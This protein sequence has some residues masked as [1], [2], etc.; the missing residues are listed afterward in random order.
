MTTKAYS[1]YERIEKR[2]HRRDN[3]RFYSIIV[4]VL[5]AI[6]L[7]GHLK[8]KSQNLPICSTSI[9]QQY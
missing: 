1:E 7:F 6:V 8:V 3:I 4:I 5:M 2:Y 9:I